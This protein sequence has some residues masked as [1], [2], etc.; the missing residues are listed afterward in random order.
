[1][2]LVL[3]VL[4]S[5]LAV[6]FYLNGFLIQ[7]LMTGAFAFVFL[8]LMIRSVNCRKKGCGIDYKTKEDEK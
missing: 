6:N 5:A 8:T 4:L 1:M 7:A 3:S 2:C